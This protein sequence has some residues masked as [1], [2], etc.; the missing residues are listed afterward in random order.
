MSFIQFFRILWARR[1]I[2]ILATLGCFL[3]A[4]AVAK[5]LPPVYQANSRLMLDI[6]KPDPV[7]GQVIASQFARA[8]VKTQIELIRDYRV[9]GKVVD[10]FGWTSSPELIAQYQARPAD[11]NRDF[12]RWLAQRIINRTEASLLEGSNILEI[13]FSATSPE[14]ARK[15]ADALRQAYI[16]QT[17]AFR[18]EGAARNAEWFR[19][20]AE[21]VRADLA[22]AERRKSNFERENGIVL[23]EDNSDPEMAKLKALAQSLPAAQLPN[24]APVTSPSTAQ[25]SQIDAQIAA[26]SQTYGPNHPMI[27]NLQRQRAAVAENASRELASARAAAMGSVGGPSIQSLVSAQ[28]QK[29]LAQ[30]GKVNE[31]QRLASD[32]TILKE[33]FTK[34]AARAADLDQQAQ[35]VETGL[36]VLGNAVAPE[37]PESPNVPLI[38][39]GSLAAGFG[40]GI[41]ASLLI[42]L[43]SRRVR[44]VED[45]AVANAPVIGAMSRVKD[46]SVPTSLWAS[47]WEWL[48]FTELFG[49][50]ATAE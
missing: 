5:S 20:Q 17:L 44:G 34:T 3:A 38:L 24:L 39:F 26:A 31:A 33:Q 49:K 9:A 10:A 15:G 45:M 13:S 46:E 6:V 1:G 16:D 29:V 12:R 14:V 11:D 21:K 23:Q 7:T 28:T 41:L 4:L 47:I 8:F 50:R 43:L 27:Q 30:R 25:L 40:M 22:E 19:Q 2:T 48:G 32:V 42:E 18:R 36:T 35:S 37:D